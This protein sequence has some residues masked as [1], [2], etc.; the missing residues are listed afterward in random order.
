MIRVGVGFGSG[1]ET[2]QVT[3]Q[4]MSDYNTVV[5]N[6]RV[7]DPTVADRTVADCTVADRTVA[8]HTV[9]DRTLWHEVYFHCFRV[10]L[11]AQIILTAHLHPKRL[12][13]D[14]H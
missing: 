4:W 9:A 5:A 13:Q 10:T 6:H 7:A 11:R 14:R 2:N 12:Q 1:T 8:D 3:M